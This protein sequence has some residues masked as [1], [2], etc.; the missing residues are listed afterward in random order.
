MPSYSDLVNA[1]R[2]AQAVRLKVRLGPAGGAQEHINPPTYPG[3]GPR[4][5]TE[6]RWVKREGK[7]EAEAEAVDCVVLDSVQSQANRLELALL[8]VH[9]DEGVALP[10]LAVTLPHQGIPRTFTSLELSHR[11]ADAVFRDSLLDGVPFQD[12]PVG[13]A[14][15]KGD[16]AATALFETDPASLLHGVWWS[17]G[18]RT[19]ANVRMTRAVT[20]SITGIGFQA[21]VKSSSRLDA[22]GIWKVA[23]ELI[24]DG[25]DWQIAPTDDK[26]KP[27]GKGKSTRLSKIHHGNVKPSI[28]P[29]GGAVEHAVHSAVLSF[30][31]LRQLRFP[32]KS[33]V[34]SAARDEAGR[35]MLA[36]M[37][38]L[39]LAAQV[40]QGYDLRAGCFLIPE[41]PLNRQVAEERGGFE[42]LT[43]EGAERF[44]L[45]Y[46]GALALYRDAVAAVRDAGFT[47]RDGALALVPTPKLVELKTTSDRLSGGD[48]D[49]EG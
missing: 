24:D 16:A 41:P 19:R 37:G 42:L 15:Q 18:L 29:L 27:V 4:H 46:A 20:S 2:H 26:G 3:E 8:G 17:T 38:L 34:C 28:L 22:L 25:R 12:S 10:H 30:I 48:D 33:G 7:A 11:A 44:D 31:R 1:V 49:A 45:D 36:A 35:A 40:R 5:A 23:V 21:G 14:M 39:E 9:R 43:A 32:D 13:L 47:W 6:K